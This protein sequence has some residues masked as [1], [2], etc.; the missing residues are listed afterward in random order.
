MAV[1]PPVAG[2]GGGEGVTTF[3]TV[4]VAE[5]LSV[6]LV[7]LLAVVPSPEKVTVSVIV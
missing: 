2:G 5:S 7:P 4:A 1:S 3:S 6:A